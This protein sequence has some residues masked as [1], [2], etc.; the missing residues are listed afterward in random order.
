MKTINYIKALLTCLLCALFMSCNED[1]LL[2]TTTVEDPVITGFTPQSGEVG[3]EVTIYGENLQITKSV[4]IGGGDAP[5]KYRISESQIVVSVSSDTR[6]GAIQV[7]N[8]F[9]TT[10]DYSAETFTVTYKTPVVSSMDLPVVGEEPTETNVTNEM[11]AENG[12][13]VVFYGS[14]LHF[15]DEVL[16]GE[17]S[18]TIITQR[19][20]E[21]VVEVPIHEISADV[22]LTLTYYN[23]TQDTAVDM[24]L[25]HVIV[26]APSITSTIPSS[27]E[28][29]SPI[30]LTGVNMNLINTLYVEDEDGN[31]V[32]LRITSKS[33]TSITV[34]ISTSFFEASFTGTLIANYNEGDLKELAENFTL[35]ADPNEPRYSTYTDIYMDGRSTNCGA[36]DN[37]FLDLETGI[38]YDTGG[39]LNVYSGI[40]I[41]FYDQ[42]G[43][44]QLYG[45]HNSSSTYKNYKYNGT[46]LN[47]LITDWSST[48]AQNTVKFRTLD[49][50][51][52]THAALIAAYDAGSIVYLSVDDDGVAVDEMIA[53]I[54]APSTSSPKVYTLLS[55]YAS[56]SI[57]PDTYCYVLVQRT[58]PDIKYGIIKLTSFSLSDAG[59]GYSV[60]FDCIW[61]L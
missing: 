40:D 33:S 4:S 39:V 9:D 25:F 8:N 50:S 7:V 31:T 38:V 19:T 51:E 53:A 59:H 20:N 3:T 24:G 44:A 55:A 41:M 14:D 5:I 11:W 18:A 32:S 28:K 26:L 43:Y 49:P 48:A 6:S 1:I 10:A 45:A 2:T 35:I 47:E 22:N 57:S 27:L 60:T 52:E 29:Y 42:T 30:I 21:L 12:Q 36:T 15:V 58:T 16:F 13:M 46:P 37:A 54:D 61:S 56:G 17:K 34:D 23:G